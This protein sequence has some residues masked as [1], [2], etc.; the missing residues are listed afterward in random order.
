MNPTKLGKLTAK[1][2]AQFTFGNQDP[3]GGEGE[4]M[5]GGSPQMQ[6]FD[7]RSMPGSPAQAMAQIG[8]AHV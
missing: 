8:R 4:N 2:A 5:F 7:Y 3:F 1:Q 6:P